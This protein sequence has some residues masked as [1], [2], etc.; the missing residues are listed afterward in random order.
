MVRSVS[1][2]GVGVAGAFSVVL[3]VPDLLAVVVRL[4]PLLCAST[5]VVEKSKNAPTSNGHNLK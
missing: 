4:F 3:P 2:I 1:P 5:G